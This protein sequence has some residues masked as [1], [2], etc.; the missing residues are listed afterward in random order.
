MPRSP[1]S[2][3]LIWWKEKLRKKL[4]SLLQ[5]IILT[6][7]RAAC[8]EQFPF[9]PLLSALD[10][11]LRGHVAWSCNQPSC[12]QDGRTWRAHWGLVSGNNWKSPGTLMTLLSYWINSEFNY[13]WSSSCVRK[14]TYCLSSILIQY[15]I[16]CIR[17]H[18]DWFWFK[19]A[20]LFGWPNF[21][22]SFPLSSSCN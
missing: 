2:Q 5:K 1:I 10:A 3:P 17:K 12:K 8:E 20:A 11:D 22:C 19:A 4:L 16:K 14:Q 13:P 21:F 9:L 15:S 6:D 18:A 7:K